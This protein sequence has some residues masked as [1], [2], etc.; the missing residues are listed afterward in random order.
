MNPLNN[1]LLGIMLPL[2]SMV[3]II[4]IGNDNA[5]YYYLLNFII[6][7]ITSS[8]I[9]GGSIEIIPRMFAWIIVSKIRGFLAF[10]FVF[11]LGIVGLYY[12]PYLISKFVFT[13]K[14]QFNYFFIICIILSI[15]IAII[16]GNFFMAID[17]QKS[18][19]GHAKEFLK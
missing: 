7:L 2:I 6:I 11:I 15:I 18:L 19:E 1:R 17:R 9:I 5:W 13:D 12:L 10:L 4:I 16:H 3:A 8:M 14:A